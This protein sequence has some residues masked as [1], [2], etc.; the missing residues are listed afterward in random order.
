M[1]ISSIY[2]NQSDC[3]ALGAVLV[4]WTTLDVKYD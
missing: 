3:A 4:S 1:Y 2:A